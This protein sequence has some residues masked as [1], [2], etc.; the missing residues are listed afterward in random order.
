MQGRNGDTDVENGLKET[1]GEGE[2]GT[3]GESS[4]NIYTLSGVRCTAGEKLLF[5]TGSPVLCSVVTWGD[6]MGEAREGH[7]VHI[8]MAYLHYCMAEIKKL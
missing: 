6:G 8:I 1:V 3:Y 2:S 7:D 5:S 4:I